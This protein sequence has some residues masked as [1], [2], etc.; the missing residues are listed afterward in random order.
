MEGRGLCSGKTDWWSDADVKVCWGTKKQT[1][2]KNLLM[3]LNL[4]ASLLHLVL[5]VGLLLTTCTQTNTGCKGPIVYTYK[6][7][8]TWV[9][10]SVDEGDSSFEM[11]PTYEKNQDLPINLLWL[12]FSFFMLSSLAHF[13]IWVL[14]KKEWSLFGLTYCQYLRSGQQPLRW[15]E[16]SISASIMSIAI[17]YTAGIRGTYEIAMIFTLMFC[18]MTYGMGCELLSG[19]EGYSSKPRVP[20]TGYLRNFYHSMTAIDREPPKNIAIQWVQ[21]SFTK[22]ILPN[23]VGYVPYIVVWV[24]ILSNYTENTKKY[25]SQIPAWVDLIVYGQLIVFTSFAVVS[26]CQQLWPPHQYWRG[27]VAYVFLSF[28]SKGFLGFVLAFSVLRS[29]TFEEAFQM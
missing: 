14:I 22:R 4:V 16:Y 18:T 1:S 8:L 29:A 11:I 12:S 6:T 21:P 27:E 17:A 24:V 15:I 3:V 9:R 2:R 20:E 23:L 28:F 7:N 10:L 5:A 26:V 13:C 25:K 19:V